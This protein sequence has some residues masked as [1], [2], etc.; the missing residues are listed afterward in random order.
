[1]LPPLWFVR[2][3]CFWG[4][5]KWDTQLVLADGGRCQ[6]GAQ[7]NAQECLPGDVTLCD[8]LVTSPEH[9]QK[10]RVERLTCPSIAMSID[11]FQLFKI[12]NICVYLR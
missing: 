10:L 8:S 3:V 1:M 4:H 5:R 11:S 12:L 7:L 9:G 2:L 6:V